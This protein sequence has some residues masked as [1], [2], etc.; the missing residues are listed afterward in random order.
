MF[1]NVA[2]LEKRRKVLNFVGNMELFLASILNDMGS[3][4]LG[5]KTGVGFLVFLWRCLPCSMYISNFYYNRT[6]VQF[7]C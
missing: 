7:E 3:V 1:T 5:D 2:T 4:E 6:F